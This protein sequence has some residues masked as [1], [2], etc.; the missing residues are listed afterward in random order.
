LLYFNILKIYLL[1]LE[2]TVDTSGIFIFTKVIERPEN[3][4]FL[5]IK[6]NK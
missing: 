4:K 1:C 6:T 2:I 5:Y 3:I